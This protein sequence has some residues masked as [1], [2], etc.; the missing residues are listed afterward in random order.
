MLQTPGDYQQQQSQ[1][2]QR[3]LKCDVKNVTNKELKCRLNEKFRT[4]GKKDE[5]IVF[6][7][8][9]SIM[10]YMSLR[11]TS[12]PL[13][14]SI[15]KQ[16]TFYTGGTQF[17]LNGF[18]FDAV[19]S[20]YTYLVYKDL[21]YSEPLQARSRL[22][23]ELILFEFPTL[24]EAFFHLIKQQTGIVSNE[25]YEMQ[26]GFL[27]DGFNV[28]LKN[29]PVLY[30]PSLTSQSISIKNINI[31]M[32]EKMTPMDAQTFTL[33][34]DMKM[35]DLNIGMMLRDDLQVYIA[36]SP[37]TNH[38][39]LN[40]F[41]FTCELPSLLLSNKSTAAMCE[42]KVYNTILNT[43]NTN[44]KLNL[45]HFY[46]GNYEIFQ[47]SDFSVLNENLKLYIKT[48]L[49]NNVDNFAKISES[50]ARATTTKDKT[51]INNLLLLKQHIYDESSASSFSTNGNGASMS[52][53]KILLIAS[54]IA[55]FL[56]ILIV[57]TVV[58]VSIVF[59]MKRKEMDA[60]GT[61]QT[62]IITSTL[63]LNT[64][65]KKK[66]LLL[67][68]FGG[69][70]NFGTSCKKSEKQL[71]LEY[72]SMLKQI[73]GLE[74]NVRAECSQLFQQLHHDYVN[75]LNHDLI[76][77]LGL[78]IWNYKTYLFNILFPQSRHSLA[79]L[80][81]VETNGS[82]SSSASNSTSKNN[83]LVIPNVMSA[84][85]MSNSTTNSL[86]SSTLTPT[87]KQQLNA[88]MSVYATIKSSSML[89]FDGVGSNNGENLN[90]GNVGEAMQLF[91]Q[92]I[93]NKT[94]LLT[95]IQVCESESSGSFTLKDKCHF[96]SLLTLG[97]KDNLPYLYS[98][99]K[100]LLSEYIAKT[101]QGNNGGGSKTNQSTLKRAKLL[102]R[103]Y[104]S[105]I[106]PLLTNWLA[107]FMYDFQRDTQSA[108]HLFRLVKVIKFF[109]D[110]GPC[111]QQTHHA[112]NTLSEDALLKETCLF[113]TV[114]VN[115]VNQCA[116]VVNG[117]SNNQTHVQ[118]CPL[119]DCDTIQ[120]AK[121]KIINFLFK[122]SPKP[123]HRDVDLE[124][125]LIL[126]QNDQQN[127]QQQ[128]Q[129]TTIITLRE[130]EDELIGANVDHLAL[131]RLLTLKDY[132][133]QN[134]SFINLTFKQSHLLLQQQQQINQQ[135]VYQSMN[136]EYSL[137]GTGCCSTNQNN[138]T[139]GTLRKPHVPM[140]CFIILY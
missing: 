71:K 55:A 62:Q 101:F 127:E 3:V 77:T 107:M 60:N 4:L 58:L 19:Q 88:T 16:A 104:E 124:L 78:P 24:P 6:D 98:I 108:T 131:K 38:I 11:V 120:Q 32:K 17:R 29:M 57:F 45:L 115:V 49:I 47:E 10:H 105:L 69:S 48:Y 65:S 140:V 30:M 99:I 56:V 15:D 37:C 132:N 43:L 33:I 139:S 53:N 54:V 67:K 1:P 92:L 94:F 5:R 97:L 122:T 100:C 8:N 41:T 103:S 51:L 18:N 85:S 113:Q 112:A 87:Q 7:D 9:M 66:S 74:L 119:L 134:G 76:Y 91:D 110:M 50:L 80:L 44:S 14:K 70:G 128:Q 21:W 22:S 36:C 109:L 12:D 20:A 125:C 46:L 136:N 72:E 90:L 121:E 118:I 75:E 89:R 96:A 79:N 116:K 114:Y 130:T 138:P 63:L 27:M 25:N 111:D 106:E 93:H 81:A 86:L 42:Q 102:F 129:Q 61:M 34:I 23:N 26:I 39:W 135:N 126:I 73:D 31:Q 137:Y 123:N 2:Q 64:R 95:F 40:E 84:S 83:N 68:K 13:V 35:N 52:T 117:S 59:K 82:A 133:I 28:T